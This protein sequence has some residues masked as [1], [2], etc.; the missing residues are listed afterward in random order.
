[1]VVAGGISMELWGWL[2]TLTRWVFWLITLSLP[3][4]RRALRCT[5]FREEL[6][7]H[8]AERRLAGLAWTLR[9]APLCVWERVSAI[10]L[11][12]WGRLVGWGLTG[13]FVVY[14]NISEP[15]TLTNISQNSVVV[16][17]LIYLY[18]RQNR[19]FY[20]VRNMF[21]V[22]MSLGTVHLLAELVFARPLVSESFMQAALQMACALVIAWPLARLVRTQKISVFWQAYPYGLLV[23]A[24]VSSSNSL[25]LTAVTGTLLTAIAAYGVSGFHQL[26]RA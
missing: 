18:L 19:S 11:K 15:D 3:R 4:E 16:G 23:L 13:L 5:E 26:S 12:R 1:M 2:A 8:Y 7:G 22:V 14:L 17:G 21:L 25:F 6:K 9:L 20:F 10:T 24:G